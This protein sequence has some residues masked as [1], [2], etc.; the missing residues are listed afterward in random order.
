MCEEYIAG[1]FGSCP[2]SHLTPYREIHSVASGN[3]VRIREGHVSAHAYWT[4]NPQ[5]KTRYKTDE[6]YEEKFRHLFRQS[7]RR[8]L[9]TDSPILAELS[10]GLDSSSIVCMTDDMLAREAGSPSSLD[11]FSSCDR[12]EPDED[13]FLYVAKVEEKRGRAGYHA[14]LKS[15]GD[16]FRFDYPTFIATPGFAERE[17]FRAAKS[18]VI[19]SGKY[20]V[21]FSGVGGDEVLGQ[22]RDPRTQM[23][24]LLRQ[25][26]IVE[27][28]T[29]LSEWSLR[30]RRSWIQLLSQSFVILM[31]TPLRTR[32]R[33]VGKL[34]P[35]LNKGFARRYGVTDHLLAAA[36]GKWL[37]PPTIRE[38]YQSLQKMAGVMTNLRPSVVEKRYPF[39]DQTLTEFLTSIPTDQL[40]RPGER[41]S[42]LR[43]A[44]DNILPREVLLRQTKSTAG[45]CDILT[46]QKHW[47][48]IQE[49]LL[50]PVSSRLGYMHRGRFEAAL[51]AMRS[52]RVPAY[53]VHL[54]RA[55]S[56]ELW[57]RDAI[58]RGVISVPDSV[59][60]DVGATG[61]RSTDLYAH[62]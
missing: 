2:E 9:R 15:L 58:A 50:S 20:R 10:G 18:D 43:R 27:L 38:S 14:E 1:Y 5:L 3:F 33:P 53:V 42:L 28:I 47:G 57:L 40:L 16:T 59:A 56:L 62:S 34:E 46:L 22:G 29:L 32:I 11:T 37:W 30:A 17:E 12:G 60:Q 44:L 21:L 51:L 24:D 39:L 41:R 6:E 49:I 13:D 48:V 23:A 19:K 7:I 52:G 31:P 8:R 4:F 55:L 35:W 54:L 45:R 36:E 26:R 25:L 61:A